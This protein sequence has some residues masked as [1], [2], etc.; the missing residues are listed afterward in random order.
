M[1]TLGML[2]KDED[3]CQL[4]SHMEMMETQNA[5][6]LEV[7]TWLAHKHEGVFHPP[8]RGLAKGKSF[9][10]ANRPMNLNPQ[11]PHIQ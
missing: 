8:T 6:M 11:V 4:K 1:V 7:V 2:P 5:Y 9:V 3:F 10:D